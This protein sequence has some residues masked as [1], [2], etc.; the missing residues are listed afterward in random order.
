MAS[1]KSKLTATTVAE[2]V[3]ELS[4]VLATVNHAAEH[5]LEAAQSNPKTKEDARAN[6]AVERILRASAKGMS[7]LESLRS[8]KEE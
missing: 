2:I 5:A 7:I 8:S 4:Q 6:R 3:K 1:K